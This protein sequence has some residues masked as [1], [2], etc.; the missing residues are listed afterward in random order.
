MTLLDELHQLESE[1]TKLISMY[2]KH[3]KQNQT[4]SELYTLTIRKQNILM[5]FLNQLKLLLN[6]YTKEQPPT[7]TSKVFNKIP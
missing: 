2:F 4:I 3:N 6:F 1:H 7:I 5:I